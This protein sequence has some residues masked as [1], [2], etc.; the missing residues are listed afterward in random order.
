M[1]GPDPA[2]RLC[3]LQVP[4]LDVPHAS[5]HARARL[6]ERYV[7]ITDVLAT[8][9]PATLLIVYRGQ[10]Q[11]EA[12]ASALEPLVSLPARGRDGTASSG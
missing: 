2:Q 1:T 7:Q 9:R 5:A 10:E 12:W 4:G 6:L 3:E 8:T 11:V